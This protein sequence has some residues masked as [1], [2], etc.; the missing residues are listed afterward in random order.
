MDSIQES[1]TAFAQEAYE[2]GYTTENC[3]DYL[4]ELDPIFKTDKLAQQLFPT[5][6]GLVYCK[7]KMNQPGNIT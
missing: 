1:F 6:F 5:I 3:L 4:Y 2:K 7:N